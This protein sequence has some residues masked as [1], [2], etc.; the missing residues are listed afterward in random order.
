MVWSCVALF[1]STGVIT[2]LA[3]TGKISLGPK[4]THGAHSQHGYYLKRLFNLLVVE[5]IAT[6]LG[7]YGAYI[8]ADLAKQVRG[9]KDIVGVEEP[10][11]ARTNS[12]NSID[13]IAQDPPPQGQTLTTKVYVTSD[14]PRTQVKTLNIPHGWVYVSHDIRDE[15]GNETYKREAE[16]TRGADG[17]VT[18]V[19]LRASAAGKQFLGPRSWW[20][21][22]LLVKI[23]EG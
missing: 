9:L 8:G 16:L 12:V 11:T 22:V 3:L 14:G 20:G 23:R 1:V 18:A 10:I 15:T 21:G 17:S 5:I 4:D 19:S 13:P 2:L 6:S 7:V